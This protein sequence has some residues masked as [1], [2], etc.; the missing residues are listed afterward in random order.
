[1]VHCG[2]GPS[3]LTP[4]N[5]VKDR[6]AER[7]SGNCDEVGSFTYWG[8][9]YQHEPNPSAVGKPN[10]STIGYQEGEI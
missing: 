2:T 8:K 3:Y 6:D 7:G 10:N 5:A 1:M 9:C 4:I